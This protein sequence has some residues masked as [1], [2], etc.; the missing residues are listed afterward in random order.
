M[1]SIA[2]YLT[3][4]VCSVASV[5]VVPT[6]LLLLL[7]MFVPALGGPLLSAWGQLLAW[8]LLVPVRLIRWLAQEA[9]SRRR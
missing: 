3:S 7:R 1:Q 9:F 4:L 5:L 6:A 2:D 8:L